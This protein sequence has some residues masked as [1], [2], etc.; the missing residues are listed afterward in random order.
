RLNQFL[1]I[2]LF[3]IRHGDA[4]DFCGVCALLWDLCKKNQ[5][6][7]FHT[8]QYRDTQSTRRR[9]FWPLLGGLMPLWQTI[10]L[11]FGSRVYNL[12]ACRARSFHCLPSFC[13]TIKTPILICTVSP[14]LLVSATI[15]CRT[16]PV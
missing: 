11:V 15:V 1:N 16:I 4:Q 13:Q 9:M 10:C 14:S 3:S 5:R 7:R 8:K 2:M 12:K 6:Q